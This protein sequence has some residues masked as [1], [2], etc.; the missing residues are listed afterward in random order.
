MLSEDNGSL[1]TKKFTDV[2]PNTPVTVDADATLME[3]SDILHQKKI[4]NIIV[5]NTDGIVGLIDIQDIV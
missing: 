4:D 1:L 3:V 5:T 2:E